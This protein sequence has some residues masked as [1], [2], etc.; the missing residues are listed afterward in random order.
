VLSTNS[1]QRRRRPPATVI[2]VIVWATSLFVMAVISYV[3]LR[4]VDTDQQ[5]TDETADSTTRSTQPPPGTPVTSTIR[6]PGSCVRTVIDD[7]DLTDPVPVP[8]DVTCMNPH[9]V[10][11]LAVLAASTPDPDQV[12]ADLAEALEVPSRLGSIAYRTGT[13]PVAPRTHHGTSMDRI[14][15]ECLLVTESV[16]GSVADGDHL[17]PTP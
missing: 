10:E 13:T 12:C 16:T 4:V 17:Q 11:V 3:V 8:V 14:V 15:L 5:R 6:P 2:V 7:T 9:D 1:P